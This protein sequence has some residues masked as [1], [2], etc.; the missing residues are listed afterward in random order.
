MIFASNKRRKSNRPGDASKS[1]ASLESR[2]LLAFSV[3]PEMTTDVAEY[4]QTVDDA[5]IRVDDQRRLVIR[6]TGE[7][8][9][10]DFRLQY[11][12]LEVNRGP[13]LS[14]ALEID[15]TQYDRI[16]LLSGGDDVTRVDGRDLIAQMHPDRLWVSATVDTP[17][18]DTESPIQI[19][20]SNFERLEVNEFS[21][22][23]VG[24]FVHR[25]NNRI[26]M[27]GN[28]GVDRLD[29]T[30]NGSFSIQTSVQMAGEGYHFSS[31][32][33]G[34]LFV[35]GG[36]GNDFASLAGTRGYADD[37]FLIS[38]STT[39]N[40]VYVGRDNFSQITNE[41]WDGRFVDF[42]TQRVDLLSGVDRSIVTDTVPERTY[43]R[44]DGQ[45]LVG[46]FRRFIGSEFIEINGANTQTDTLTEPADS[47]DAVF[48]EFDN[49]F[50]YT[51]TAPIPDDTDTDEKDASDGLSNFGQET[52][53]DYFQWKFTSFERLVG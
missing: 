14:L 18:S 4:A 44:V 25:S 35:S 52:L 45:D 27:Y 15:P 41:L 17:G 47:T 31:N 26:R 39:G 20:G 37:A 21:G 29:M 11:N 7:S 28:D 53:P 33:F 30:S 24:P 34:D 1:Y 43:Y 32:V 23:D 12:Y 10:I 22:G 42:E 6:T 16:I 38:R 8:N 51:S 40:D 19:F 3:L 49:E 9:R 46:G 36:G 13:G 50:N 5:V 48:S 2:R